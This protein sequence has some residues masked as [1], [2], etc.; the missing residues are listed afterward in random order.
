MTARPERQTGCFPTLK[1]FQRVQSG[2]DVESTSLHVQDFVRTGGVHALA[3]HAVPVSV[4]AK[5]ADRE[6][7]P[8][9]ITSNSVLC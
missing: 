2:Q 4:A 6:R 3:F 7:V 8:S 1:A 9:H 5:R